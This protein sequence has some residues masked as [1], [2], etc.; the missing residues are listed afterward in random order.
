MVSNSQIEEFK[1][2]LLNSDKVHV[3]RSQG[4]SIPFFYLDPTF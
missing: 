2:M 4:P 3:Q 1:N